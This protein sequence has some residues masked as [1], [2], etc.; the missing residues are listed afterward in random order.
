METWYRLSRWSENIEDAAKLV[1]RSTEKT[2]WF[3]TST[4]REIG[5]RKQTNTYKWYESKDEAEKAIL[6]RKQ[7]EKDATYKKRLSFAAPALLEELRKLSAA[8]EC[9]C[10]QID[11]DPSVNIHY[12]SA[13][14]AIKLA[15]GDL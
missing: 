7:L 10:H 2:V 9:L 14:E 12:R 8:Y 13:I 4:G 15:R 6:K 5:E 1:T 3:K 11:E